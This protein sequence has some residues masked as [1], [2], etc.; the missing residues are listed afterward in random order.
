MSYRTQSN[1]AVLA[2]FKYK[3]EILTYLGQI[4]FFIKGSYT[5]Y[6]RR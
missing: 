3:S 5:L 4:A 6:K 1:P 2:R